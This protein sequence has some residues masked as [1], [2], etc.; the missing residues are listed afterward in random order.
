MAGSFRS[1][2]SFGKRQEFAV[3]GELLRRGYDVY[4]TL[5]DDQGI[6]CIIRQARSGEVR[7][8]EIQVEARSKDAKN[9][10][11]FTPLDVTRVNPNYF[12][13]FYSEP[14]GMYWVLPSDVLV[15]EAR[16]HKSG[17]SEGRYSLQFCH[18]RRD[19]TPVKRPR[20]AKYESAFNLL[21]WE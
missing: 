7:Y 14:L 2:V 17:Q 9:P 6:D 19:G 18:G 4:Q 3:I 13:I 8:L 16:R 10:G 15:K 21:D 11:R 1:S 12:F 20:F 5:V